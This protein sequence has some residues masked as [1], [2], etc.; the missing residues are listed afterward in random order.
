MIMIDWSPL[1]N[2]AQYGSAARNTHQVAEILAGWLMRAKNEGY[3]EYE[4]TNLVGFRLGAHVVG[5][6]GKRIVD[7]KIAKIFGITTIISNSIN[8]RII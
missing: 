4:R 8:F 7:G 6:A 5:L 3:V 1:S 2:I